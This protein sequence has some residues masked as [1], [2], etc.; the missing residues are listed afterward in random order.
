MSIIRVGD[1]VEVFATLA[2]GWHGTLLK[3]ERVPDG[4]D[5]TTIVGRVV[6]LSE[7]A[8]LEDYA[9]M[10]ERLYFRPATVRLVR[11]GFGAWYKEHS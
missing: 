8:R 3:V 6:R 5:T 10:G 9:R 7:T 4:V 1:V 2:Q 11:R